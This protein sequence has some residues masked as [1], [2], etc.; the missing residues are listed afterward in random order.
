MWF[1]HHLLGLPLN[2]LHKLVEELVGQ[3]PALE[4]DQNVVLGIVHW[5]S[6]TNYDLLVRAFPENE[7]IIITKVCP[8]RTMTYVISTLMDDLTQ[9]TSLLSWTLFSHTFF[10]SASSASITSVIL[11]HLVGSE[12]KFN[13]FKASIL[14]ILLAKHHKTHQLFFVFMQELPVLL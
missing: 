3:G 6:Q 10:I 14:V 11:E 5:I 8:Q 9:V 4:L 13:V 7:M 2:V 1:S 12:W